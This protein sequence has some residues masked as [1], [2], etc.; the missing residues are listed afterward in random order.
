MKK[1]LIVAMI[2][3]LFAGNKL[4]S[5][6]LPSKILYSTY[7]GNTG[8]DDA[9]VVAV[10]LVGNTYLGCHSSSTH[11]PGANGYPYT[12]SG[13]M[14][15]FL[16]KLNKEG[17]EV[18]YLIK[19]GGSKWDAIQGLA[20]DSLGNIYGVG[21]TYSSDFPINANAFQPN[22]GGKSDAF[23]VK[24][25]PE[26]KVIW[27]TFLGG[28]KDEDGRDIAIDRYGNV[29]I[30]GRTA[31]K[32]FPISDEAL[33]SKSA[34]GIDAFVATLDANGKMLTST[35]LG[36]TGDDIGFSIEL[37]SVGQLYIGGTTNSLDFPVKNAIQEQNRGGNDVFLAVIDPTRSFIDFASYLG[38]EG[39]D[40]LYTID[41]NA[42]GDV[43]IMGVTNSS[44]FPTTEGTFQPDFGGMRDVFITRLNLQKKEVVFSTY[45]GG[46]K[47]DNPRNLVLNNKGHAF[48]VGNTA[49]ANFPVV[50]TQKADLLGSHDAFVT[51][52]DLS[53]SFL[54]YSA[55][56]GGN[57]DDLF[58]GL[59]IGTDGSLTMSGASN[60]TDFPIKNPLQ[61]TFLGGRF[62]M[63]VTRLSIN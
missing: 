55:L 51:M 13:G 30:I 60:S 21:T 62:D 22:F 38:G 25:S 8:T 17:S 2:T 35:Y 58:E 16:I 14:D 4:Y 45:L 36:G 50:K 32:D 7:Y 47:D 10:D 28:K 46:K 12:L 6:E 41:I 44:N 27:S 39:A 20:A 61:S 63:I 23:V 37:D 1:I 11:L 59:A 3:L 42:F 34:G 48:V 9:D 26:G 54:H 57:G 19:L 40:Q 29:H 18:G 43:F 24:I 5:Q 33:Q 56:F 15:A 49:S 52:L 31:S 53:G